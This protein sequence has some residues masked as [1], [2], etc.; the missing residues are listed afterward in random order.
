METLDIIR[1]DTKIIPTKRNFPF[2]ILENLDSLLKPPMPASM[3][4]IFS[5][6]PRIQE[7]HSPLT[8]HRMKDDYES[9]MTSTALSKGGKAYLQSSVCPRLTSLQTECDVNRALAYHVLFFYSLAVFCNASS[10]LIPHP[11][12]L[13]R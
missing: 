8:N 13:L 4:L 10:S 7:K 5:R 9:V 11:E 1:T 2:S 6:L 12:F 3:R